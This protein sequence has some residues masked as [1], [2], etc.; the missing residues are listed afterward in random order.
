MTKLGRRVVPFGECWITD[1][2]PYTYCQVGPR[3][4]R[5]SAHRYVYLEV[6]RVT[7]PTDIVI[8]H[9][10]EHPGCIRP[11]H[12]VAL[13][14]VDH[15]RVHAGTASLDDVALAPSSFH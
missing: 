1:A 13:T 9:T 4:R 7:V 15:G 10:C 14:S 8:H 11:D 3:Q 12:L 2:E 5:M 6:H